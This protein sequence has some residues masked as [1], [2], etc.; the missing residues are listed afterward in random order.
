MALRHT[1]KI[2]MIKEERRYISRFELGVSRS[3]NAIYVLII[4]M[5]KKCRFTIFDK[6]NFAQNANVFVIVH[7]YC[8]VHIF[9][10]NGV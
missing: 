2:E 8:W 3:G 7:L 9:K 10:V 5:P 1:G 4:A 6:Q